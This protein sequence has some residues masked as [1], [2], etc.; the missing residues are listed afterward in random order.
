[1]LIEEGERGLK[2]ETGRGD[3]SGLVL[4]EDAAMSIGHSDEKDTGTDG[5][6]RG[7]VSSSCGE[8][9]MSRGSGKKAAEES[10]KWEPVGTAR[11]ECPGA[12][13]QSDAGCPIYV[14]PAIIEEVK[15]TSERA[16]VGVSEAVERGVTIT[17][18]DTIAQIKV[19]QSTAVVGS[20]A[21]TAETVLQDSACAIKSVAE[22]VATATTSGAS[23]KF[24]TTTTTATS[25][26]ALMMAETGTTVTCDVA[27]LTVVSKITGSLIGTG[28][29][30]GLC[31]AESVD[32][33]NVSVTYGMTAP[34]VNP[35]S[36]P[37]PRTTMA[38]LTVPRQSVSVVQGSDL[39][40][41]V[42]ASELEI[43][44]APVPVEIQI[45]PIRQPVVDGWARDARMVEGIFQIMEIMEP[46]WI[47]L[48]VLEVAPVRF[49]DV[50][51]ETLRLTIMTVMMSQR[52][53]GV[54]LTRARLRLGSRTDREGN[55]FIELDLDFADRYSTSH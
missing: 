54:R 5:F 51:R 52:R 27:L 12:V 3:E 11:K 34:V 47:T 36:V 19:F 38:E 25:E 39:A 16:V 10:L 28:T 7:D 33:A 30:S 29:V 8:S 4:S 37:G 32:T 17:T 14:P 1:V 24:D 42:V 45:L 50:D 41:V 46:P 6:S 21:P 55:A 53:C 26:T 48:N 20:V 2:A 22:R 49:P 31:G 9:I 43:V 23:V 18:T 13:T 35:R 40:T 44:M 15:G